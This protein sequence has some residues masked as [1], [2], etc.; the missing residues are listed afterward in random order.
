METEL[1]ANL[2]WNSVLETDRLV[3]FQTPTVP[4]VCFPFLWF[5]PKSCYFG[6]RWIITIGTF[7]DSFRLEAGILGSSVL[8][9]MVIRL[10][11][12]LQIGGHI[13]NHNTMEFNFDLTR[14]EVNA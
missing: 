3:R 1:I 6:F 9:G 4:G 8:P 5:F 12:G 7:I 2:H 13:P 10:F 14:Q 11:K